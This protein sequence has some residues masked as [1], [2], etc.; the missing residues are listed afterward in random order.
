MDVL[1]QHY[2]M[3]KSNY[4]TTEQAVYKHAVHQLLNLFFTMSESL[5][6][7]YDAIN[8]YHTNWI[9]YFQKFGLLYHIFV[10]IYDIKHFPEVKNYF[11]SV[12][13]QVNYLNFTIP[14]I[15]ESIISYAY[16]LALEI[17]K[18]NNVYKNA[19]YTNVIDIT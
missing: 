9:L 16:D 7:F 1:A 14:I 4:R 2:F 3:S 15:K 10:S 13:K 11:L 6:Y 18:I 19:N 8:N 5:L 12:E 17:D